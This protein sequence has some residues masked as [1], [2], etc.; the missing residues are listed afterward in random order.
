MLLSLSLLSQLL[1]LSS[2]VHLV[3]SDSS[4]L[5]ANVGFL[6]CI[7]LLQYIFAFELFILSLSYC[8]IKII[9]L[10]TL[11]ELRSLGSLFHRAAHTVAVKKSK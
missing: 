4:E 11:G 6:S 1:L 9:L 2:A 10:I 7:N 5:R 8:Y 3:K